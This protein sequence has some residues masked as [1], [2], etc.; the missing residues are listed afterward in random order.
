MPGF[1]LPAICVF[2]RGIGNHRRRFT[3]VVFG[4]DSYDSDSDSLNEDAS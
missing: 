2:L 1:S 3:N 4:E